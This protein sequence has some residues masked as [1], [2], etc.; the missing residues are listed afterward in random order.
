MR[1]APTPP[2]APR[3]ALARHA[4][5]CEQ[6]CRSGKCP[7]SVVHVSVGYRRID[8][9]RRPLPPNGIFEHLLP[10]GH[11]EQPP[12]QS[13]GTCPKLAKRSGS[14]FGLTS[15]ARPGSGRILHQGRR[16]RHRERRHRR[17]AA[18]N[19]ATASRSP[20]RGR[21]APAGPA[22]PERCPALRLSRRRTTT[23][24]SAARTPAGGGVCGDARRGLRSP[25]ALPVSRHG[26][27]GGV[28]PLAISPRTPC[29]PPG[30]GGR[31]REPRPSSSQP[32]RF[33]R[34][35]G[36]PLPT[37]GGDRPHATGGPD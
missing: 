34:P 27:L 3:H 23:W 7:D 16:F 10:T 4:L 20:R 28:M 22:S 11:A 37:C 14:S 18:A 19:I 21:Q 32:C 24:A 2:K 26:V 17:L 36:I 35:R 12:C 13:G 8:S 29:L 15:P 9:I 5:R 30:V 25:S 1:R 31:P 6:K 33:E